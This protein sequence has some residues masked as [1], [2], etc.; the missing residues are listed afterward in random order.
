MA[1]AAAGNAGVRR[2]RLSALVRAVVDKVCFS[3]FLS[4]WNSRCHELLTLSS[5]VLLPRDAV[6]WSSST[7]LMCRRAHCSA[8]DTCQ[9]KVAS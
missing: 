1:T 2:V 7:R 6:P 9:C 4:A 3:V 5:A 8:G